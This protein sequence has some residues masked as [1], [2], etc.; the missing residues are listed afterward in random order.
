MVGL[1]SGGL[2]VL[3]T[4]FLRSRCTK[5]NFCGIGCDRTPLP[6]DVVTTVDPLHSSEP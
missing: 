1:C 2:G 5:L 3:L 6:A 4:Y